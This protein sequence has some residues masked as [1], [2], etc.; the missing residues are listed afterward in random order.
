MNIGDDVEIKKGKHQYVMVCPRCKSPDVWADKSNPL[1]PALGL[2][3]VYSCKTCDYSGYNFPEVELSELERLEKKHAPPSR[4][5]ST[6][7]VS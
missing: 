2:P 5:S 1:Q 3:S 6:K 7:K 4:D